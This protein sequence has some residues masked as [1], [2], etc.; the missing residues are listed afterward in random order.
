[1]RERQLVRV[2]EAAASRRMQASRDSLEAQ[3]GTV[4]TM[5]IRNTDL[6]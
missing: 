5:S 4:T 6:S 2:S 1:M 3:A